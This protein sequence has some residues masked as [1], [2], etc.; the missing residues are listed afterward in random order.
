MALSIHLNVQD[1]MEG[2][3]LIVE[4]TVFR[5]SRVGVETYLASVSP[6]AQKDDK[7]TFLTNGRNEEGHFRTND[8]SYFIIHAK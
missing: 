4:C 2:L 8:F 5:Y 6:L 3:I 1:V 7:S